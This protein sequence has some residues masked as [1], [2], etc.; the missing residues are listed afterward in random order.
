MS[1]RD[2]PSKVLREHNNQDMMMTEGGPIVGPSHGSMMMQSR[3]HASKSVPSLNTDGPLSP[4]AGGGPMMMM[5]RSGAPP[6]ASGNDS[7]RYP[8]H[9][10]SMTMQPS[11][12]GSTTSNHHM[13]IQM[14]HGGNAAA[15]KSRYG[16]N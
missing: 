5:N 10:P 7:A 16:R 4:P 12:R 13:D 2:L 8:H 14:Q 6:M 15:I 3:I 1:E 11:N 9:Y